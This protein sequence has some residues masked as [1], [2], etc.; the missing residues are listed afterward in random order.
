MTDDGREDYEVGD[1]IEPTDAELE[2]FGDKLEEVQTVEVTD[3]SESVGD[4]TESSDES[5][6]DESDASESTREY[7]DLSE[8]S[9]NEELPEYLQANEFSQTEK[10]ELHDLESEGKDRI[11]AHQRIDEYA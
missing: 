1:T 9:V 5:S 2:S 6:E 8:M 7:P 11:T 4:E 3:S 10:N